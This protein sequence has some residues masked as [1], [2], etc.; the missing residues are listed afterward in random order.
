M[1]CFKELMRA[2]DGESETGNHP[3]DHLPHGSSIAI[4]IQS[5]LF[6]QDGKQNQFIPSVYLGKE[7][8]EN[9]IQRFQGCSLQSPWMHSMVYD[10]ME[11]V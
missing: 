10:L 8:R 1:G 7:D 2:E 3:Q 6:R 5:A 4:Q 11:E 9:G